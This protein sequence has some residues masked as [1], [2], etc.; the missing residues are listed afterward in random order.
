VEA[1][2]GKLTDAEKALLNKLGDAFNEFVVLPRQHFM[3]VQDF[4]VHLHVL[5]NIVAS[6][7]AYRQLSM[8]EQLKKQGN[9]SGSTG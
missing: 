8:E 2:I 4:V 1:I 3:E 7:P 6:R 9:G 5:Q